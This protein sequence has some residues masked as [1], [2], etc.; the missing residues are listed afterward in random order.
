MGRNAKIK[1][2]RR[3]ER[4]TAETLRTKI[5]QP[6][7][8]KEWARWRYGLLYI[9]VAI[10]IIII[11]L[12]GDQ[13]AHWPISTNEDPGSASYDYMPYLIDSSTVGMRWQRKIMQ[14]E[15]PGYY[16]SAVLVY[17]GVRQFRKKEKDS[18]AINVNEP[19]I[20]PSIRSK[21]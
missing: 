8:G 6:E 11:G 15:N 4:V 13:G 21:R 17:F 1:Q 5:Y 9:V 7:S 19:V 2:Q 18:T 14:W 12:M 20:G 3:Q 16:L 10:I